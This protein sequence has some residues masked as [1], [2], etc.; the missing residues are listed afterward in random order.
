V[1]L[2][3]RI[4][5]V[6]GGAG[7]LVVVRSNELLRWCHAAHGK[8]ARYIGDGCGDVHAGEVFVARFRRLLFKRVE[9][10][11][12]ALEVFLV[13]VERLAI[14]AGL[15]RATMS[16][17]TILAHCFNRRGCTGNSLG[18]IVR[19]RESLVAK[20][21]DVWSLLGVRAHVPGRLVSGYTMVTGMVG[22]YL[23]RCSNLLN[24]LP[25]V[26][27]GQECDFWG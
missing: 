9:V 17:D 5:D 4:E 23:L 24:N 22:A 8:R 7:E 1:I 16:G 21:A 27:I 2:V 20:R 10:L 12:L 3:V 25:Q 6:E 19:S 18:K 11:V 13:E 14:L 26:G 15:M